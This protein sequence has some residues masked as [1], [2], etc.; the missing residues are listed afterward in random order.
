[1]KTDVIMDLVLN[2]VQARVLGVLMEK[3]MSTPEYYPLSLHALVAGCNQKSS[4]EPVVDYDDKTVARALETLRD[5]QLVYTAPGARVPR[6]GNNFTKLHKL[7]NKEAAVLCVLLLRGPQT[8]GELR[9]RTDRLFKF[10]ALAEVEQTLADLA[11][12]KFVTTLPRQPGRKEPRHAQLLAGPPDAS[13]AEPRP[14]PATIEV[15]AENDRLTLLEQDLAS[16]RQEL[17]E[18]KGA[19]LDFKK[20]FE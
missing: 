10:G 19:F 14:E 8:A 3:E 6:Y 1:M 18:L 17:A 5:K 16:L 20:Q 11:E 15:R 12:L 9:T 4:R 7:L 2:E 13:A